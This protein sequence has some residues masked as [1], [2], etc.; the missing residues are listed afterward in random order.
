MLR[1]KTHNVYFKAV[2]KVHFL[3]KNTLLLIL[4]ANQHVTQRVLFIDQYAM[5]IFY[6]SIHNV[7]FL[8]D[9]PYKEYFL[10]VNISQCVLPNG[11]H[12]MTCISFHNVYFLP[13]NTLY[14]TQYL[15]TESRLDRVPLKRKRKKSLSFFCGVENYKTFQLSS[16]Y[17]FL[18]QYI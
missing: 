2:Y 16:K 10:R 18:L 9:T 17:P 11:E 3:G 15:W 8:G 13:I 12:L 7:Y 6:Q 4:L 1:K 5:C 14:G